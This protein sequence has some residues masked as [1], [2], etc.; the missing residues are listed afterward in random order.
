M[1]EL[2]GRQREVWELHKEGLNNCEIGRKLNVTEATVRGILKRAFAKAE[3]SDSQP[4][5]TV[6]GRTTL[7]KD[8]VTVLEWV[9]THK[10]KE[11]KHKLGNTIITEEDKG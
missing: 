4:G 11:D 3:L 7:I 10:E 8:G 5:F 6:K 2:T 9:K 1:I